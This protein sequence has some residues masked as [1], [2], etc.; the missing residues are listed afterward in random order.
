MQAEKLVTSTL[1]RVRLGSPGACVE[2]A[3]SGR[4]FEAPAELMELLAY[5]AKPRSRKAILQWLLREGLAGQEACTLL[6]AAVAGGLIEN[7]G[8]T[9][10]PAWLSHGWRTALHYHQMTI[11]REFID[12]GGDRDTAAKRAVLKSYLES[13][14]PEIFKSSTATIALPDE[15]MPTVSLGKTLLSRRTVRKFSGKG[16]TMGGLG[17]VLKLACQPVKLV[18]NATEAAL[19]ADPL[20]L[21]L[22]SYSPFEVYVVALR[23][24]GLACGA[25]HY[26]LRRHCLAPIA[27]GEFEDELGRIAI[28]QG[29]H[30]A[31]AVFLVTACYGRYM[32]R[33]RD[34]R[35]LR[36][37][38]IEAACLAHRLILA[39]QGWE[40]GAFL[41]PALRDSRAD[42]LLDIDG[43]DEAVLYLVAIGN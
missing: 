8:H 38:Y 31:A 27:S 12:M 7:E 29:V 26:D 2:Q 35:A 10:F 42:N 19:D 25:Y 39:S 11:D 5:C 24:P 37:V 33:Y 20:V 17:G 15:P 23:I 16:F 14:R 41:T 6:D 3:S 4:R 43:V 21:S 30:G 32:W 22:S 18:R 40:Q 36:N 13:D 1:A 28:G 34:S 9:R